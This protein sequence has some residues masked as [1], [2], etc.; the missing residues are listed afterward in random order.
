[1]RAVSLETT[2]ALRRKRPEDVGEYGKYD[3]RCIAGQQERDIRATIT[4]GR[5]GVDELQTNTIY[6]AK[7]AEVHRR[8]MRRDHLSRLALGGEPGVDRDEPRLDGV[9]VVEPVPESDH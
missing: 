2:L 5:Q 7:D 3:G 6:R 9:D 1:M 8:V 4:T